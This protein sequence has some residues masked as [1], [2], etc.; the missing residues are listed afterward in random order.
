M[1]CPEITFKKAQRKYNAEW[2]NYGLQRGVYLCKLADQL[3]AARK[4]YNESLE[5][6]K[7]ESIS[8]ENN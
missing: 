5:T 2:D 8:H 1:E 7:K 6:D 4:A 3:D